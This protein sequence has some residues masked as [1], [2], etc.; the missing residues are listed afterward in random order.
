MRERFPPYR[1][2]V[3]AK[4]FIVSQESNEA[5]QAPPKGTRVCIENGQRV[6]YQIQRRK[7]SKNC[8]TCQEKGGHGPYWYKYWRQGG[9]VRSQYIGKDLP[10]NIEFLDLSALE[11]EESLPLDAG[12]TV[13][14]HLPALLLA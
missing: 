6:S 7:C 4:E 9:R 1:H 13:E 2:F 3:H 5:P 8:T 11:S 14:Y 10:T 12:G